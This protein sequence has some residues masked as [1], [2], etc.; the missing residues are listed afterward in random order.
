MSQRTRKQPRRRLT[1]S[2][3]QEQQQLDQEAS[4]HGDVLGLQ[5]S[6]VSDC[7]CLEL[8]HA[9]Y[10][11]AL[12]AW[13]KARFYGKTED[14][15]LINLPAMRF[16]LVRLARLASVRPLWY[17]LMAWTGNGDTEHLG[18]GCWG[19]MFEDDPTLSPK[20]VRGTLSKEHGCANG[21]K[22][23]VPAPTHEIDIRSASLARLL[24]ASSCEYP[25]RW[26]DAMG[27]GRR[28]L[29]DCA[30]VQG[31][32]L[33]RCVK[34]NVTLAH[35]TWSKVHSNALDNGWRPF[36]AP[37]N[38]T[39]VLDMN[40]GDKKAKALATELGPRVLWQRA[41]AALAPV[42]ATAFPPLLFEFDPMRQAGDAQLMAALNPR[43]AKLH[44]RTCQWGGCH[45][46][47]GEAAVEWPAWLTSAPTA[48]KEALGLDT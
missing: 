43:V 10:K 16:E 46:S 32:F 4:H 29:N 13:P 37:S 18:V 27:D 42:T 38:L 45:P 5:T 6:S 14:D 2:L 19:G 39:L 23:I 34:E 3:Q 36:A 35:A 24:A 17:G 33:A 20:A 12:D 22:P 9:W 25:R 31:H 47:R 30:G 15:V 8:L 44:Y 40:L 11:H 21:A 1:D 41:A 26:L 7:A 48:S 28:C